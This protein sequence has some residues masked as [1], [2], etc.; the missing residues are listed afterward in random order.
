MVDVVLALMTYVTKCLYGEERITEL[1]SWQNLSVP[2]VDVGGIYNQ[3]HLGT[4]FHSV[5]MAWSSMRARFI[6]AGTSAGKS[7]FIFKLVE[8]CRAC[9]IPKRVLILVNRTALKTAFILQLA[10]RLRRDDIV[11]EINEG[12]ISDCIDF[13][14]VVVASYQ[15]IIYKGETLGVFDYVAFD[16]IQFPINDALF[17]TF[18]EETLEKMVWLYRDAVRIYFTATEYEVLPIIA[19]A[20][21]DVLQKKLATYNEDDIFREIDTENLR[22]WLLENREFDGY[23]RY[24]YKELVV[25]SLAH[26]KPCD[27]YYYLSECEPEKLELWIGA[28]RNSNRSIMRIDMNSVERTTSAEPMPEDQI[29]GYASWKLNPVEYH[30]FARDYSKYELY[31]GFVDD[32]C[33]KKT[34]SSFARTSEAVEQVLNLI[35]AE[36]KV[37]IASES[38]TVCKMIEKNMDGKRQVRAISRPLVNNSKSPAAREYNHLMVTGQQSSNTV[39]ATKFI[40]NGIDILDPEVEYVIV[41][42]TD[43]VDIVQCTGRPRPYVYPKDTKIKVIYLVQPEE[44]LKNRINEFLRDDSMQNYLSL[45]NGGGI[46]YIDELSSHAYIKVK[47]SAITEETKQLI[48]GVQVYGNTHK[49][50]EKAIKSEAQKKEVELKYNY[51]ALQK[52]LDYMFVIEKLTGLPLTG[53]CFCVDPELKFCE[54]YRERYYALI[55]N[56]IPASVV[57]PIEIFLNKRGSSIEEIKM[58]EERKRKED[59]EAFSEW[60]NALVKRTLGDEDYVTVEESDYIQMREDIYNKAKECD[61]LEEYRDL[62]KLKVNKNSNETGQKTV[63]WV[64]K[65]FAT[66]YKGKTFKVGSQKNKSREISWT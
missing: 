12:R 30:R 18:T 64:F 54:D 26:E 33:K 57:E 49:K 61:M 34:K 16:E 22:K 6:S 2:Y 24:N 21:N 48:N 1:E 19:R 41:L 56:I 35:P 40:D 59:E 42:M 25:K 37:Y 63:A 3:C 39:A 15:E 53:D 58:Q 62:K 47:P 13:G 27:L 5:V 29:P 43:I 7:S 52:H 23:T 31:I 17:N 32:L 46:Q 55:A 38:E 8:F 51:L 45:I 10:K 44:Q 65:E 60:V 36:S 14:N 9:D 66:N 11:K 50:T 28:Y 20:E 4:I